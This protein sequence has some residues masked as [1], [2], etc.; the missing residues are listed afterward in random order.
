MKHLGFDN[1][2][3]YGWGPT[4][5]DEWA[6]V[7]ILHVEYLPPTQVGLDAMVM[8]KKV[9]DRICKEFPPPYT[10]MCSGGT[11]SQAMIW[12]WYKSGQP[13]NIVSI[14][15]VTSDM[16]F[17]TYDVVELFQFAAQL[18]LPVN[19]KQF[20][21][22]NFLETELPE[23][24][25]KYDCDSPQICTYMKMSELVDKGTIMFSGNFLWGDS[26]GAFSYTHLGLQRYAEAV[27]TDT[28]AIIPFF[29]MCDRDMA[30]TLLPYIDSVPPDISQG[31]NHA[32]HLAGYPVIAQPE[33][34]TGFE[35]LKNY[36]DDQMHRVSIENRIK[37]SSQPSKR[38][39]DLLFRYP[40][41]SG[42]GKSKF[43]V[44][45]KLINNNSS[46]KENPTP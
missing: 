25:Q 32:Y 27:S 37:Y 39:F 14:S 30:R 41:Y 17:N 33:K 16:V 9:V 20:D 43:Q 8:A 45:H 23:Y 34:Q 15:Y 28:R 3:S 35:H 46:S 22:I 38:A 13:F 2:I 24:A 29:L 12:A 31:K 36:Y 10:L 26:G 18:S 44:V 21:V 19:V 7:D 1:W 6:P 5:K 4:K 40:F 42:H 11:D